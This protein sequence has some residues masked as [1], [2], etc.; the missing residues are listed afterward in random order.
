MPDQDPS[1]DYELVDQLVEEF[2]QR[3]ALGERPAI[4]E[5]CDRYPHVADLL[6]ELLPAMAQIEQVKEGLAEAE[7]KPAPP[8]APPLQHLGDFH[9][10]R[11]IGHGGMGIVYEAEQVSLGRR[12]AL[13]VLTQGTM[14]DAKHKRRF[15]REAKA[16]AKLHHTNIVPVFGTGEHD[17]TP[18]YVMQFIQGLG[19]DEVIVELSRMGSGGPSAAPGG[20]APSLARRDD[21][22]A[23]MMA[24]SLLT[25]EFQNPTDDLGPLAADGP[26]TALAPALGS[27]PKALTLASRS[28][29]SGRAAD[30]SGASSGVTLPGQSET[31]GGRKA[32]KLTYWQSVARVG[33]QVADALEYAHKQGV[34]HRDIKPSNLLLDLKGTVWVTDF[35]L[36]KAE[37]AENLTH[38]GDILGTLR[39]M[40]PEAFDGKADARGDLYSLGLT[41]YELVAFRPAFDERERNRLIKQVTTAE[42]LPLRRLRPGVPRDLETII[43]K[44]I[45]RDP[46]R[47]YQS[48]G[49][50]G[51]DLQRFLDDE[52]ILARRQT[53]VERYLRWARRN[54]G[55]AVLGAVLTAV[56]VLATAASLVVAGRMATLAQ[57]EAQA[58][59]DERAARK[60]AVEAQEREAREREQAEQARKAAE[61]SKK[62]A[63]AALK[64]AEENFARAR[65]AVNDYF[66]AVS[67]D[68]LLK[69]P[70]LQGLRAQL[71]QSALGF[72][73]DFLK[74]RGN[75]PTLR[76][77]LA[78]VYYRVG[79]IYRDLRQAQAANQSYGQARRLYEV[80]VAE[81]PD[82]ADAQD[83]LARCLNRTNQREKAIAIWEKIV[84]P[85]D[86]RY[87]PD[88]A[89]AYNDTATNAKKEEPAKALEFHLKALTVR[90]RLVKLRPDDP[91]SRRDLAAT[92]NNIAVMLS[93][94]DRRAEALALYRRAAEQG[95]Q[96]YRLQP[97]DLFL[98][99][100]VLI[101][102]HNVATT[103]KALGH[104]DEAV[105]AYRRWVEILER[106][107]RDNPDVP[108]LAGEMVTGYQELV[109]YLRQLDRLDD[110]A[111]LVRQVRDRVAEATD[112]TGPF[113]RA[114]AAFHLEACEVAAART[115]QSADAAAELE[116]ATEAALT[117]LRNYTLTGWRDASWLRTN[118]MTE[119]LR[120]RADFR[121]LLARHE[122]LGRAEAT[123]SNASSTPEEKLAAR[124]EILSQREALAG[125]SPAARFARRSLAQARQDLGQAHLDLG[126]VEEAKAAFDEALAIRQ[127]LVEE[128]PK[129]EQLRADLAVSQTTAGS[130]FAA[131]G[132]LKDAIPAWDRGLAILEEALRANPASFP[133]SSALL[134]RLVHVADQYGRV[135]LWDQAA[136]H[137]R[138]A[139]EVQTPT[140]FLTWYRYAVVLAETGHTDAYRSL[141][142]RAAAQRGAVADLD[143]ISLAR[144]LLLAPASA[145]RPLAA[146]KGL[147]ENFRYAPGQAWERWVRG[148][149]HVRAGQAS[150]GAALLAGV[151]EPDL[152]WPAVALAEHQLGRAEAAREALR[153]AD[154]AADRQTRDALADSSNR[155]TPYWENW[156]FLRAL[157]REAHQAIHGKPLPDSPYDRLHQGRVLLAL[158]QSEKAEAE[159]AAA[160]T[161]RPDDPEVWLARARVFTRLGQKDRAVADL[162]RAL[163][164]G[165]D[166]P[167]SWVEVGRTLAYLGE[168]PK[169][170][171][172]FARAAALA[173]GEPSR[174]LEAGWWAVGP[175]PDDLSLPCPP[176]KVPDPSKQVPAVGRVADL[177]WKRLPAHRVSSGVDLNPIIGGAKNVTAYAL[178]YVHAER[179]RAAELLLYA[180]DDARLWLNGRVVFDGFAAWG[181]THPEWGIRIPVSLKAG[182]NTLL[183]KTRHSNGRAWFHCVFADQPF[184]RALGLAELGLWNE[185]ADG[186]SEID[187][188]TPLDA[189]QTALRLRSLLAAGRDDEYR[190]GFA[191]MVQRFDRPNSE[192]VTEQLP[193]ACF[194]PP[195]KGPDRDRWVKRF[196][197]QVANDP[198]SA[199]QQGWMGQ[200]Y[201]RAGR[202]AEAEKS[203]RRA[204]ELEDQVWF[205]A[206]LATTC[207]HLGRAHDA[208]TLLQKVEERYARMVSESLKA[209]P[210]RA[211]QWWDH[212]EVFLIA[213]REARTLITGKD[214]GPDASEPA[215]RAR[216]LEQLARWE[217]AADPFTRLVEVSP[218]QPRLWLDRGRRL[219]E[220]G[221]W[222]E[223]AKDLARAVELK[224]NEPQVWKERGRIYAELGKWDE[225]AA[226]FNKA[227]NL[228]PRPEPKSGFPWSADRGGIDDLLVGWDE[229]FDRVTKL[230]PNDDNLWIRRL[231]HFARFGRWA[232]AEATATRLN[233]RAPN[234]QRVMHILA[235][236]LLQRGDIDGYRRVCEQMVQQFGNNRT[237][238]IVG[239]TARTVLLAPD[240]G[241]DLA[242]VRAMLDQVSDRPQGPVAVRWFELTRA[243]LQLRAGDAD[244]VVKTLSGPSA[245]TRN[246]NLDLGELAILALARQ[247]LGQQAEA[248]EALAQ[249]QDRLARQAPRPERGWLYNE[250]NWHNLLWVRLLLREAEGLIPDAPAVAAAARPSAQEEAARRER[251]ARADRAATDFALALIRFDLGQKADA[252]AGVRKVL[253]E[254]AKLA[255]EE[256]GNP[257]Y[258]SQLADAYQALGQLLADAGR[259]DDGLKET[260]QAL[261]IR[262]KLV[263]DYPKAVRFRVELGS[264]QQTFGDLQWKAARHADA[265]RSWKAG[266]DLLEAALK[267][268]P[269]NKALGARLAE[270]EESLGSRYSEYALL[271]E[272]ATY[273]T[274]SLHRPGSGTGAWT[275]ARAAQ[276][277]VAA[278]K[279]EQAR[280]LAAEA[281]ERFGKAPVGAELSALALMHA[282]APGLTD[283]PERLLAIT[284]Q[285]IR[286]LPKDGWLP[287]F[288][289]LWEYRAGRYEEAVRRLDTPEQQSRHLAKAVVAMAYHRVGQTEKARER[290]AQSQEHHAKSARDLFGGTELHPLTPWAVGEDVVLHREAHAL[291]TGQPLPHDPLERLFRARGYLRFGEPQ[292]AAAEFRAAVET[293]PDDPGVWLARSRVYDA[294][295]QGDK[296]AA[297]YAKAKQLAE[298]ALEERP[299]DVDA[300]ASLADVLL[301]PASRI[302]WT[303]LTPT[304]VKSANGTTLT[305]QPDGSMLA[306]GPKPETETYVVTTKLP[307]GKYT[308]LRVEALADDSLPEKGPGRFA[309]GNFVLS[310]ILVTLTPKGGTPQRVKWQRAFASIEQRPAAGESNPYGRYSAAAAIDGDVKGKNWG[311]AVL[312]QVGRSQQAVFVFAADLVAEDTVITVELHQ[313]FGG[314]PLG[315]F[316]IAA[317]EVPA[318]ELIAAEMLTEPAREEISGWSRLGAALVATGGDRT[319]AV[320]AFTRG[321]QVAETAEQVQRVYQLAG[322]A[323]VTFDELVK[324][325]PDDARLWIAHA[326]ARAEVGDQKAA[327]AAFTAAA[328]V[329]AG[330]V[331]PFLQAGWW[332]IGP[333]PEDLAVPCSPEKDADPSR[334]AAAAPGRDGSLVWRSVPAGPYGRVELREEFFNADHISAYALTY[335]YVP[336]ERTVTL[337]VAADDGIRLWLNGRLIFEDP[338]TW[339]DRAERWETVRVPVTLRA[340]RNVLLARIKNQFGGHHM[341]IRTD[342]GP[343]DRAMTFAGLGLWPEAAL[344]LRKVPEGDLPDEPLD[345]ARTVLLLWA[346]GEQERLRE[347]CARMVKRFGGTANAN[348]A[349]ELIHYVILGRDL[350]ADYGP[351][352]AAMEQWVARTPKDGW[353]RRCL[354]LTC[355][356]AG[357]YDK[358]LRWVREAQ[359]VSGDWP[360]LWHPLAM[361]HHRAGQPDEAKKWLQKANEWYDT[362]CR[363]A[364]ASPIP[365]LPLAWIDLV[366]FLILREEATALIEGPAEA[367]ANL[368]AL[369]ARAREAMSKPDRTTIDFDLAL[370][371]HPDQSRLWLARAARLAELKRDE[372]AAADF[373]RVVALKPDDAEVL[374]ERGRVY[375][376]LKMWDEAAADFDRSLTLLKLDPK[377]NWWLHGGS[378]PQAGLAPSEVFD[379]LAK[380]RPKDRALLARRMHYLASR[381]RFADAAAVQAKT[382][383]LDPTDEPAWHQLALLRLQA[384]DQ[385]GYRAACRELLAR[386]SD[387]TDPEAAERM[388][389]SCLLVPDLVTDRALI[390]RWADTAYAGYE[391][392]PAK[393]WLLFA[394]IL[395]DYRLGDPAAAADR[396]DTTRKAT[397]GYAVAVPAIEAMALERLGRHNQ[398]VEALKKARSGAERN[399]KFERGELMPGWWELPRGLTILGEAEGIISQ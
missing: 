340:G 268:D 210:H 184:R 397:E 56:L 257:E 55:I 346:S 258:R 115:K 161:I 299:G 65:A 36:A 183:L 117:A 391:K 344:Q 174:F 14:R 41:L 384:G 390:A 248:R 208:R 172:A 281:M 139:F 309:N 246:A 129:N 395:A 188:R 289:G 1:R 34:V 221:R 202:F 339:P 356:R 159:F 294:L 158:G 278:G 125:P 153:Q 76:K 109:A 78:H 100:G 222:D 124:R 287:T 363:E 10:L 28:E 6:R 5:Y 17:G 382:V 302:K 351:V 95:E 75:D 37:G 399:P 43:H 58:A 142:A 306:S 121:D 46:A 141:V 263:A 201:L 185:C 194:L 247:K 114:L 156:A 220:L 373:A 370:S 251:K 249:A 90:E 80:L 27:L 392:E 176:E 79:E 92:L 134:E 126:Q 93:G 132:N 199:Y 280:A 214:P 105:A 223:A 209:T 274:R 393:V 52:P 244:G 69:A 107:A 305:I 173:P 256:P 297:D 259:L 113:F 338:T 118:K 227:L 180:G 254:R 224:P 272:A 269:K 286:E 377:P 196:E 191:E 206:L 135:G 219:A 157:R 277:W 2:A 198:K 11:E 94:K 23:V 381:G 89:W 230:R 233:E 216:A 362:V 232:E 39:Y 215:L 319:R 205:S 49:E 165:S 376:D 73:Q 16:A 190:H 313:N 333:Y 307:A 88:L 96:A 250:T 91:T 35:G 143:R 32:R 127:T 275:W 290:F 20:P 231:Q 133:V 50:L 51:A 164:L 226:D 116:Q 293:R 162:D 122:A 97:Y 24:R 151:E 145:P 369:Q 354:A 386:F 74:E 175:Y 350:F 261:V 364:L 347:F 389:T 99:R 31:S 315:R 321:V 137:Y 19:L 104:P 303:V 378:G 276:A 396:I 235:L 270:A 40:P 195:Q 119:P 279:P 45:D 87:Q 120:D 60:E 229:V 236:L 128:A 82:D 147:A 9:I 361:I 366:Q 304:E 148:F 245:K 138:R 63:E 30:A 325:L 217:K 265:V 42:P 53:Q 33:V 149:A 166:G 70:G 155:L 234:R 207:H 68:Q 240:A 372:D 177:K 238:G 189:W 380:L 323:G 312:P 101:F 267:D 85:E 48:A 271:E 228:A 146:V 334:P 330:D 182:R 310:E 314:H 291:I 266:I 44:A 311:W 358:A 353:A 345:R 15:E 13:K 200:A 284:E 343:L 59:G 72:Y 203:L 359:E 368:K 283:D 18:Y 298:Q 352:L 150:E 8:A 130:L 371:L 187:R 374:T 225:A 136:R 123:A 160:V 171:A 301:D 197:K 322:R 12:V 360:L 66:T 379:R 3:Y 212:Q 83:G 300:A 112:D 367:D 22:S 324:V 21:V 102:Q 186:L 264:N 262:E 253:A 342:D 86:P 71:L 170:D 81:H 131:A 255:A 54:P 98:I 154:L 308:A 169:A 385:D 84:R 178:S 331:G 388:I 337:L 213:L 168:H 316:R 144:V 292:K 288:A 357:Q 211:P 38:T 106:R 192:D 282:L 181:N 341:H 64:K 387:P 103:E 320:A 273:L 318:N 62:R 349:W 285:A 375:A 57:S 163:Q 327:D 326:R 398:A 394:R 218:D 328:K 241:T 140:V 47:R 336:K 25:G 67:E 355:Y 111:R 110:A 29:V 365:K 7:E 4:K 239:L 329:A 193:C 295:G 167:R 152:K 348:D 383:E 204:I 317:T 296:A 242:R 335:L 179:D 77:E 252:E 108:G 61:E 26:S 237:S 260:R 332:I 243:L